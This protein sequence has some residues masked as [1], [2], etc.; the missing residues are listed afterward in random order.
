MGDY[1]W[2]LVLGWIVGLWLVL[3]GL[4]LFMNYKL[5]TP[6]KKLDKT[7]DK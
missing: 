2:Q 5:H 7:K 4:L 3:A 1:S 6:P